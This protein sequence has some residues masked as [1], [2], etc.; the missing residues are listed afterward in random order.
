MKIL[1]VGFYK[2]RVDEGS[3]RTKIVNFLL[4]LYYFLFGVPD[5]HSHI[6][7]RFIKKLIKNLY[8]LDVGAGEGIISFQLAT[9]GINNITISPYTLKEA[10]YATKVKQSNIMYEEMQVIPDDAQ[11]LYK[12]KNESFDQ[13]LVIDV[14]EHVRDLNKSINAVLSKLKPGGRLV[15]SVPTNHYPEF[16]GQKFDRNIGHLRHFSEDDLR[17]IFERSY[18]MKIEF[19]EPYTFYYT[20]KLCHLYYDV[21]D[22]S[23]LKYI[24]MPILNFISIVTE[25]F[26]VRPST[27]IAAVFVKPLETR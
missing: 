12:F 11:Q 1:P 21:L 10:N 7:Y 2:Y 6:R 15:V 5:L 17:N 22:T 3:N 23:L 25:N 26:H 9:I 24:L 18:G 16:F 14:F 19:L 27:E 13:I 8:T 20:S 4:K